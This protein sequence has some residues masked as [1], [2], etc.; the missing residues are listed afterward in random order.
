MPSPKIPGPLNG[1]Y[2]IGGYITEVHG[3]YADSNSPLN[4]IQIEIPSSLRQ[5]AT[6]DGF[7]RNLAYAVFKFYYLNSFHLFI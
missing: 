4:A 1:N 2:F 3:S 7:A 5:N 6:F